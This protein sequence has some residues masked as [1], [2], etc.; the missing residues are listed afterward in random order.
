VVTRGDRGNAAVG[1]C[2]GRRTSDREQVE[3]VGAIFNTGCAETYGLTTIPPYLRTSRAPDRGPVAFYSPEQ[4]EEARRSNRGWRDR[5]PRG[6]PLKPPRRSSSHCDEIQ[7]AELV[8]VDAYDGL[9]RG[10]W[11]RSLARLFDVWPENIVCR[12]ISEDTELR[13]DKEPPGH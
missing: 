5:D 1:F 2:H 11:L 4:I 12:S 7:D 3:A 6:R 9:R 10:S 13:F 8:R